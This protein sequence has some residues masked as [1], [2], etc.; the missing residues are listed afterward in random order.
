MEQEPRTRAELR[1]FRD[2]RGRE[3]F[4][5]PDG[6][7]P[8]PDTPA[9]PRFIPEYHNVGL[10]HEDRSRLFAGPVPPVGGWPSGG[11]PGSLL[12]DGFFRGMWRLTEKKASARLEILGFTADAGDPAGT[13]DAVESEA[14]AMLAFLA[15][16]ADSRELEF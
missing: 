7:L 9:P 16:D 15:P 2:Q 5:V 1:T 12:V 4:D 6:L 13:T 10:S 11:T 8:D 3:L 14:R